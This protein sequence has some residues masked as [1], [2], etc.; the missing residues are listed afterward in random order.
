MEP[1]HSCPSSSAISSL[2]DPLTSRNFCTNSILSASCSKL[3]QH[4][5]KC[6]FLTEY[7]FA[8]ELSLFVIWNL[9][10][11]SM[12]F[13]YWANTGKYSTYEHLNFLIHKRT[14]LMSWKFDWPSSL[15]ECINVVGQELYVFFNNS[16]VYVKDGS[17]YPT[18]AVVKVTVEVTVWCVRTSFSY[19]CT[20]A[21]HYI[22]EDRAGGFLQNVCAYW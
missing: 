8:S 11:Y 21:F 7:L 5:N 6:V 18:H 19:W 3:V 17:L 14:V 9:M 12:K 1:S 10:Y 22:L 13:W 15:R 16:D 20:S 2:D 4:S